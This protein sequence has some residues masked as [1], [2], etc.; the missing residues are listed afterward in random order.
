M[1]RYD[2][3]KQ[4]KTYV[5]D[6]VLSYCPKVYELIESISYTLSMNDL[7]LILEQLNIRE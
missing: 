3:E 4:L 5:E 7:I 6:D 2:I 1:Y